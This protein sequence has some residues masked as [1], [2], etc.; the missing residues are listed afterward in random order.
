[1]QILLL[2]KK[3]YT[4]FVGFCILYLL[5]SVIDLLWQINQWYLSLSG[6]LVWSLLFWIAVQEMRTSVKSDWKFKNWLFLIT[7]FLALFL[8]AFR[9]V[10]R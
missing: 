10:V 8:T 9:L 6:L 7:S 5:L 2:M 3:Y 1:M 4:I